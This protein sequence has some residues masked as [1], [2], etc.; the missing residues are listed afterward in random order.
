MREAKRR[1]SAHGGRHGRGRPDGEWAALP[2]PAS[3]AAPAARGDGDG[4]AAA[5]AFDDD[6]DDGNDPALALRAAVDAC[7]EGEFE[8]AESPPV[9]WAVRRLLAVLKPPAPD[10]RRLF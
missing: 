8:S 1:H 9:H 6:A 2:S 7:A 3:T 10:A 5:A 4:A